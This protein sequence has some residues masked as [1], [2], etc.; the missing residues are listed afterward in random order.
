MSVPGYRLPNSAFDLPFVVVG[1]AI[2]RPHPPGRA[3]APGAPTDPD[4]RV[5]RIRLFVQRVRLAAGPSYHLAA[6]RRPATAATLSGRSGTEL[7]SSVS[8]PCPSQ[9]VPLHGTPLAPRGPSGRFPRFRYGEVL[10]LPDAPC[11]SLRSLRSALPRAS[12]TDGG[13]DGT[14]QVPGRPLGTCPRPKDPGRA[15]RQDPGATPL[16]FDGAAVAFHHPG[17]VGHDHVGS[18]GAYPRGPCPRC[19]RFA[20]VLTIRPRK[21][22][23]PAAVL[24]LTGRDFHPRVAPR[25]FGF[26]SL[27]RYPLTIWIESRLTFSIIGGLRSLLRP[28]PPPGLPGA[29]GLKSRATQT[30]SYGLRPANLYA[31]SDGQP[32]LARPSEGAPRLCSTQSVGL[33]LCSPGF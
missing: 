8:L 11:A 31:T 15:A 16:R 1:T 32:P 18:F 33:C 29:T 26:C 14:S 3:C 23:F 25:G 5:S 6:A 17:G 20:G 27:L 10:R 24:S 7:A 30:K 2:V 28:P 12:T 9:P 21:T 19:L 22:R 4:V 13:D